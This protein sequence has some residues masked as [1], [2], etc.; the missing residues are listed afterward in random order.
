M[1]LETINIGDRLSF[2]EES[3]YGEVVEVMRN[4]GGELA[5]AVVKLDN[6]EFAALDL[7]ALEIARAH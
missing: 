1:N 5:S 4:D 6:G 2:Y 3:I 7:S